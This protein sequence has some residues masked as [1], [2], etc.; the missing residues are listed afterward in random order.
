MQLV[1]EVLSYK[2][3]LCRTRRKSEYTPSKVR[4]STPNTEFDTCSS[5]DTGNYFSYKGPGA[6]VSRLIYPCPSPN[7]D[8]LGTHLTLDLDGN[9][10]FGPD[11]EPIGTHE[12]SESNPDFWQDHLAPSAAR[13]EAIAAAV[14]DYLPN[15]DPGGLQPDYAGVRPNIAPAGSGFSD[16]LIRHS[17]DRRGLVELLGFNSPGLTSSLAVGEH[18]VRMV[19][20]DVWKERVKDVE[21]LAL[22]WE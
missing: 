15:I 21:D 22:G 7:L 19:R 16:F 11:V 17:S 9:V 6:N 18:V 4:S 1:L 10:K 2:R 8:S 5:H 14:Q 13:L 3:A 12:S 20:K